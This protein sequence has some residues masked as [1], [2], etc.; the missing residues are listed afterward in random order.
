MS[1]RRRVLGW[2]AR[3]RLRL[4]AAERER[5]EERIRNA[6]GRFEWQ[7]AAFERAR[8]PRDGA[9][10]T[11]AYPSRGELVRQS[12]D[13]SKTILLPVIAACP[14]CN[15]RGAC[16]CGV[17]RPAVRA[18]LESWEEWESRQW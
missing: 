7:Q 5:A 11:N 17:L 1:G 10:S 16:P 15:A 2:F 9:T 3:R 8:M 14:R 13:R 12:E 18:E 6:W 4:D